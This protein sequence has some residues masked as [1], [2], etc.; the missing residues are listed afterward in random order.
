M[1]L[2]RS[3]LEPSRKQKK[4]KDR[5]RRRLTVV[6][7]V[8][9]NVPTTGE[10]QEKTKQKTKLNEKGYLAIA[11]FYNAFMLVL[12]GQLLQVRFAKPIAKRIN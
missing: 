11:F 3:V 7:S 8:R 6:T 9:R 1:W 5:D 10:A 2:D 12:Q 4:E